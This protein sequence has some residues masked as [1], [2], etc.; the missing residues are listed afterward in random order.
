MTAID[1][2]EW[3][4]MVRYR[5]IAK[6]PRGALAYA[7]LELPRISIDDVAL[8]ANGDATEAD[9]ERLFRER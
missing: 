3:A 8:V 5:H 4:R 2:H 9:L 7:R 1:R 6:G